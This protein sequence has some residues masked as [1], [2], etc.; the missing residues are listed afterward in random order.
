MTK[1]QKSKKRTKLKKTTQKNQK[2]ITEEMKTEKV[3]IIFFF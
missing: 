2:R 1:N 3:K